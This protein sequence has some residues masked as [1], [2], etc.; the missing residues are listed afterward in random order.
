MEGLDFT[1]SECGEETPAGANFCQHCGTGI[2]NI[3]PECGQPN[4]RVAKFGTKCGVKLGAQDTTSPLIQ[5]QKPNESM[6]VHSTE[7]A[8]RRLLTI[9]FSDLAGSTALS[10]KLGPEDYRDLIA[11][12]SR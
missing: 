2:G 1:C 11:R 7:V 9:L 8:E 6:D 5:V 4:S 3:C 10:T 12:L